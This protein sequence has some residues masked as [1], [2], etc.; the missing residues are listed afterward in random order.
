MTKKDY[1]AIARELKTVRTMLQKG[2]LNHDCA[3]ATLEQVE[4]MLCQVFI[5]N[6]P[7]FDRA[8]FLTA[9]GREQ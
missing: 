4:H 1:I 8:R 9:C 2:Q 3:N 7:R 6:N 5:E